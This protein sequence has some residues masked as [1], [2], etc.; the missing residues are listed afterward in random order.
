M[1]CYQG[2]APLR[3]NKNLKNKA[4]FGTRANTNS[5]I[6]YFPHDSYCYL[7]YCNMLCGWG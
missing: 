3:F 4:K 5:T 1:D 2:G 6:S 7:N